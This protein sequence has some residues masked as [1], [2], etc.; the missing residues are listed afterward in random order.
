MRP[1]KLTVSAFGPYAD[2]TVLDLDKLGENGL[3]LITGDTGAGKTTIFDAITYALYGRA[4]G[5]NRENSMLRSKYAAAD[6]PTEVE[7]E[8]I[9]NGKTY[10]VKRNPE[11]ERPAKKGDKMTKQKAEATLICP[12]CEPITKQADVDEKI[13]EIMGID[14]EQFRQIAMI[15]QG[16][17]Q[18]LLLADTKERQPILSRIFKTDIYSSLQDKLSRNCNELSRQCDGLRDSIKQYIDGIICE[19][20]SQLYYDVEKAKEGKLPVDETVRVTEGLIKNDEELEERLS[21]EMTALESSLEKIN[22]VLVRAEEYSKAKKSL[23]AAEAEHKTSAEMLSK[24][25]EIAEAQRQRL[26]EAQAAEE[27]AAVLKNRLSMYD[28]LDNKRNELS[29][30]KKK[31][32]DSVLLKD[33]SDNQLL[34]LSKELEALNS[35]LAGLGEAGENKIKYANKLEQSEIRKD[36]LLQ[37]KNEAD[38]FYALENQLAQAQ[39][40]VLSAQNDEQNKRSLYNNMNDAFIREQAGIIAQTLSEGTPCPVCGSLSHPSPAKKSMAAPDKKEVE[41]A[42]LSYENAAKITSAAAA[43]SEKL[44]GQ[45][46]AKE[47][48]VRNMSNELQVEYQ[49]EKLGDVLAEK[50]II[51]DKYIK[52]LKKLL[53]D[54]DIKVRRKKELEA[55]MPVK[56]S[57]LKKS[58]EKLSA[59]KETIAADEARAAETEKNISAL[60]E[61]LRF[62]SR[63]TA[64]AEIK[65]L[66]DNAAAIRNSVESAEKECGQVRDTLKSLDGMIEQ[67]KKQLSEGCD[68]DYEKESENKNSVLLSKQQL[69]EKQKK[70]NAR[71]SK[72]KD[73]LSGINSRSAELSLL[74]QKY[75]AV[76]A[77]SDTANG[78][79]RGKEKIQLETFILMTYF[80]RIISRANTHLM[81]MT[82]GQ[83]E[84]KRR[85]E[86]GN[87]RSKSGL[88]LDVTDH[89]NGTDRS[90]KTLSG[91]ESFKASLSLALGLADEI[92]SSAGGIKLDTMFVDEGFGSLD[93]ESL[94]QSMDTLAGLTEG[95]RLVGIISHVSTLRERIDKQIIIRKDKS[96]GSRAEISV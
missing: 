79:V 67:L 25:S 35:E 27:S 48:L 33:S 71:R 86:A 13:R 15:A 11:Y 77:L 23:E 21:E 6:T 52:E 46:T 4:S 38:I 20:D 89:Y 57:E 62:D 92:Q 40:K 59:L 93:E 96:G 43:E 8:F 36:K 12:D 90:V 22:A 68:V 7:L 28:E 32:N 55:V 26:P 56:E 49:P 94:R 24:L 88:E 76:K 29:D 74:E 72:N 16:D 5:N 37:L 50:L 14:C 70:L 78:T 34:S 9:Y 44:N 42:K 61:K 80:D 73:A 60:L 2:R 17:F 3:Y 53:N 45:L 31:L 10:T 51:A 69:S 81:Q 64:E 82:E 19:P 91:G 41:K 18:K 47:E 75:A 54:E 1:I 66:S 87:N 58:Q 84:L 30:I 95:N 39:K 63:K 65:K 83:Y 85:L